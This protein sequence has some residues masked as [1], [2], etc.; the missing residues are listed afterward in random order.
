MC[1]VESSERLFSTTGWDLDDSP[2]GATLMSASADFTVRLWDTAP[3]R[4]RYQARR[5]AEPL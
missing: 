4:M 2:D 1:D 3:P 5:E